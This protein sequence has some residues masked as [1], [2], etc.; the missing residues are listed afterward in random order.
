VHRRP[1]RGHNPLPEQRK[2]DLGEVHLKRVPTVNLWPKFRQPQRLLDPAYNPV[3]ESG[4]T[5]PTTR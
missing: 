4:Y 1:D 5:D 2:R 3:R